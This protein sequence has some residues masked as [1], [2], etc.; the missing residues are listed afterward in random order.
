MRLQLEP[1]QR[2]RRRSHK[3]ESSKTKKIGKPAVRI[4]A[5]YLFIV[6]DMQDNR[7]HHRRSQSIKYRRIEQSLYG[8]NAKKLHEQSRDKTDDNDDIK[9]LGL[10]E[11]LIQ[12]FRNAKDLCQD[13]RDTTRQHR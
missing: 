12:P 3:N 7:D 11:F 2:H 4:F 13:I 6:A 9:I 1:D 8:R 10:V 5:H